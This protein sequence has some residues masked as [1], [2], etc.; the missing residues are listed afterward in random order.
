M[1]SAKLK[2]NSSL[3]DILWFDNPIDSPHDRRAR[4]FLVMW[5]EPNELSEEAKEF[6]EKD[7]E[8]VCRWNL[9]CAGICGYNLPIVPGSVK[10]SSAALEISLNLFQNEDTQAPE[11]AVTDDIPQE[12]S[13]CIEK[14]QL[15]K[16]MPAISMLCIFA[17]KVV[18]QI[19]PELTSF[20]H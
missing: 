14:V 20:F 7:H 10:S 8:V 12:G 13:F 18:I 17:N 1:G 3:V 15:V 4:Q 6:A 11:D 2:L 16:H 19:H 9:T 5:K